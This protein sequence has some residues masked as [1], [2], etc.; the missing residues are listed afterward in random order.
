M[1]PL[2]DEKLEHYATEHTSEEPDLM[3]RLA[4]E[5]VEK[6]ERHRMLTGRLEG[7][8]LKLLVRMLQ[9]K[10]VLEVGTFTGYGTLMMASSL[11]V[12]GRVITCDVDPS[13]EAIASRY[14]AESRHGEKI[15]LKMGPA[16]E[17]L[18]ELSGPF[19]LV[20]IDADKKNYPRYYE[21]CLERTRTGG[22]IVVD[23]VLWSGR[24]LKPADE[25]SR[26]IATLNDR[27]QNDDSVDNVLLPI[28]D[29]VML[30]VKK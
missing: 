2:I 26:A 29:G 20:F 22:A 4:K 21:L 23:N 3:R 7:T 11:P 18:R 19:D 10:R 9:A 6:M 30:I 8:F 27:V 17:T 5:T 1:I 28:R 12:G 13:A 14:F 15:E 25:E 16:L 24:V